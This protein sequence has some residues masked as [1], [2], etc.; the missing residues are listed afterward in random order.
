MAPHLILGGAVG[1]FSYELGGMLEPAQPP[2]DKPWPVDMVMGIYDTIAAFDLE[3]KE[4]WVIAHDLPGAAGRAPAARRGNALAGDLGTA[5]LPAPEGALEGR[6][7]A[8]T[9]RSVHEMAFP[10]V[11][12]I[13]SVVTGRGAAGI[14]STDV[15]RAVFPG[16][17]VTGAPKIKA[18]EIIR[19]LEPTARGPYCGSIAW[20]GFDGAMDSSIVIRTLARNGRSVVAQAGGGI[21]AE[22][23]PAQE[24][25]ESLAKVRPL[26]KVVGNGVIS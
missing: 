8:E 11:H 24:Y 21:V 15:L 4:A 19:G 5:A 12:H 16:G 13:V 10:A 1:F 25:E 20:L 2:K 22:S 3:R 18:M 6:W 14:T 26:L 7:R 17:S 9:P 23:D